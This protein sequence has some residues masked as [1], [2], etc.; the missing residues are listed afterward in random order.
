MPETDESEINKTSTLSDEGFKINETPTL[1]DEELAKKETAER[2]ADK[3]EN[4]IAGILDKT[5][6]EK[7]KELMLEQT[8]NAQKFFDLLS[9][10][11]ART[12]T[13][14]DS[15]SKEC[16]VP[17]LAMCTL[18]TYDEKD[19]EVKKYLYG[20]ITE[21]T[22]NGTTVNFRNVV[23][24]LLGSAKKVI[25]KEE[26]DINLIEAIESIQKFFSSLS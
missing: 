22:I 23:Q 7:A 18:A 20:I 2:K 21:A 4:L 19:E 10:L 16:L 25:T 6:E 5:P 9:V 14:E 12:N 1:A 26:G 13:S 17:I 15:L 24:Q 3:I 11:Y 8:K